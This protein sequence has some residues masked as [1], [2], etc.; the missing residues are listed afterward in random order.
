MNAQQTAP[1][2]PAP[3]VRR[4]AAVSYPGGAPFRWLPPDDLPALQPLPW[5]THAAC[6]QLLKLCDHDGRIMLGRRPDLVEH[7]TAMMG[8]NHHDKKVMRGAFARLFEE[9]VLERDGG[10]IV[11]RAFLRPGRRHVARRAY[12]SDRLP[13]AAQP[14]ATRAVL[15]RL[16]NLCDDDGY[17]PVSP[18]DL[19]GGL[20]PASPASTRN[21]RD[22]LEYALGRLLDAGY[23]TRKEHCVR[24]PHFAASQ[25]GV[26]PAPRDPTDPGPLGWVYFARD[27]R[28]RIKIGW[29]ADP[30]RRVAGLQTAHAEDLE[31]LGSAPGR[32]A[33]ETEHHER[34]DGFRI[35]REW[36]A[37]GAPLLAY[38]AALPQAGCS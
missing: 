6:L 32:K 17:L 9:G 23:L 35:R 22:S 37:P 1:D 21:D 27:D 3:R 29:S 33:S 11:H 10:A 18:G 38:I 5:M 26:S 31:L 8:A 19:V 14:W 12:V 24:L 16:T 7:A 20:A 28:G 2:S 36:F 25:G 30:V 34:F 15:V 4:P 13:L